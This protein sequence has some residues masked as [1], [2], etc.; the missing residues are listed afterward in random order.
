MSVESRIVFVPLSSFPGLIRSG[1]RRGRRFSL[2]SCR[3]LDRR[4]RN[5]LYTGGPGIRTARPQFNVFEHQPVRR[6]RH[7]EVPAVA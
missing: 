6:S 5:S 3:W 1:G 4:V 2:L 7:A